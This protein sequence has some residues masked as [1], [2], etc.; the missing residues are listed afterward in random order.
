[1]CSYAPISFFINSCGRLRA[2]NMYKFNKEKHIHTWDDKPLHGVTTVLSVI[3]KPSLIQWAANMAIDYIEEK[4]FEP[5]DSYSSIE[6]GGMVDPK[7]LK[8][9]RT[10]HRKKKEKA[11]DWG[12]EVHIEIERYVKNWILLKPSG[13][14]DKTKYD[15]RIK[16]FTDWVEENKVE[17]LE[18]EK[19][20]WSEKM[21]V[22]GICD[23]VIK[24]NGKKYIA[25]IKTSSG[26]YNE[27]FYQMAAYAL[28]LED[29]GEHK[30][31]EGYLVINL[32]KDGTMETKEVT[33]ML[34]NKEAFKAALQLHKIINAQKNG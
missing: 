20:V 30:D 7:I 19:H 21:W 4:M 26:I 22:G 18:S 10:A 2:N 29:M 25:D 31:V 5:I 1:M 28:C 15:E 16:L 6:G 27:Y 8:E 3:A 12:S 33:D 32:K 13:T 23:L 24:M 34:E 9:A 11:G 14:V 17:L